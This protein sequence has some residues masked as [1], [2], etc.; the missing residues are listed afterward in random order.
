MNKTD[1][2]EIE[3]I[4]STTPYVSINLSGIVKHV[5]KY[6]DAGVLPVISLPYSVRIENR[7]TTT[8]YTTRFLKRKKERT[9]L[10]FT[11]LLQFNS[12]LT[13]KELTVW[14]TLVCGYFVL[15]SKLN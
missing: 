8:K 4:T 9:H 7:S 1:I 2:T 12:P 15:R 6:I 10:K 11:Y 13:D 3:F 14:K 5:K